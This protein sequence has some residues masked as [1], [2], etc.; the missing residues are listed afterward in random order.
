[1]DR[2]VSLMSAQSGYA[3]TRGEDG[4]TAT[5]TPRLVLAP[6]TEQTGVPVTPADVAIQVPTEGV[7][8]LTV[9]GR[10][11]ACVCRDSPLS[12]HA[13]HVEYARPDAPLRV[14]VQPG[15]A[16]PVR[17]HVSWQT[18]RGETREQTLFEGSFAVPDEPH[19]MGSPGYLVD[20]PHLGTHAY[21]CVGRIGT[22][23]VNRLELLS[24]FLTLLFE[25]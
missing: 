7:Y 11:F 24:F 17:L 25:E 1:M 23:E 8:T 5:L 15:D 4:H 20:L 19:K 21:F 13:A 16:V 3:A 9:A 12:Q 18:K 2:W 14:P 10:D 6:A 22:V